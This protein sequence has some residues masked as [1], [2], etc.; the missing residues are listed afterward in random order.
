MTRWLVTGAGGM[1]GHDLVAELRRTPATV[2]TAATRAACDITD[3]AAVRAA[4]AGHDVVV[5]AAG[6]TRVDDAEQFEAQATAV[7]GTGAGYLAQACADSGAV[8][9][10]LSTDY[11]FSGDR[12]SAYPEG[13]P[14]APV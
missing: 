4:V 5:N 8:L 9:L 13:A 2:V 6:W 10:Q 1:L 12:T 3:P 11:V 14:T 7:N